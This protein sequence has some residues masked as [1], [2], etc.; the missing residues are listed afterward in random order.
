MPNLSDTFA[1]LSPSL[2]V[3]PVPVTPAIY[4]ELDE[5]F[6]GFKG[7]V[8]V[9]MHEFGESW[10]SWEIH[11]EGDELVVLLSGE[12]EMV[13][14]ENDGKRGVRLGNAGDYVVVPRGT[15][16]TARISVAAR[17][18]FVTPGQGTE[19]KSA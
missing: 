2:A 17:M 8:L 19:N 7:H 14:D 15:W 4:Q 6:D 9:A 3:T 11:P 18:L 10:P 5:R 13:L 16:H 1:V 12:A